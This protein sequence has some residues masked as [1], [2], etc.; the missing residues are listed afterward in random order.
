M[1]NFEGPYL[2][3][4]YYPED[5][6]LE[7]IDEDIALMKQAGMNLMRVGEFAWSRMEG[8]EG[9][10]DFDW[11]HM[12]VDKLGQSGIAVIMGTPTCTPP[13]WLVE[14]Y[15]EVLVV[16][17]NGQISQHG[18][19][20]HACPNNLVYRDYCAKIATKL[21]EEFGE[22]ENII[23]WQIDNE[24][25]PE[26]R[27]GRGCCCPVCHKKFQDSMHKKF[28]S[29]ESLNKA[30]GTDLWS[31]T[32][33]SF[34]QLPLPRI[35]TWHHPSLLTAWM[36]FQSDSYIEFTEHQ[37]EILHKLCRQPVGTDMMCMGG[38]N[39][40]KMHRN[41]DIVQVNNYHQEHDL[42][43]VV[44]WYDMIRSLKDK[45]FWNTETSTC[46]NGSTA[47]GKYRSEGFCRANSWLPIALGGE[48]VLYWLWRAHWSGQE[49]MHGSVISSS[50][51]PLH[52]INEVK[53]IAAGLH[54]SAEFINGT[55]PV[56]SGLAVHFSG[57]AWLMFEFQPFVN[58]FKYS[59]KLT[60]FYRSMIEASLRADVID[61]AASLD[62]YRVICSPFLPALDEASLRQRIKAWVKA[63]GIW[64]T[65]PLSDNLTMDAAKFKHSPFG[66]LEQLTETY[67][68]YQIPGD[69]K[70]FALRWAD[71]SES[72]GSIWYDGFEAGEA[73]VLATYTEQPLKGLAAVL[74]KKVGKG[75]IILLGTMPKQEDLKKLMLSV[76]GQAGIEPAA[77]A[78]SN[79]LVVPRKGKAG[80]GLI[81]VEFENR[82]AALTLA[83]GAVDLLTGKKHNG[84]VKIQPY[85]V[86]VLKYEK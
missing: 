13:I 43:R 30:W 48:A 33:Q 73:E 77:E 12:A 71:G 32:Y 81:A 23:G 9:K 25:Y 60:D 70:D 21:A 57:L 54:S 78:S 22:D 10:Y 36:E 58:N 31:Q 41:L 84:K 19:R 74:R 28:G 76:C 67:C 2:G 7:Q 45:P 46:W 61:P 55:R 53:E 34:S 68:N 75:Q 26:P 85:G 40:Y 42:W 29:I 65:G 14:K 15:P 6:P 72:C 11:L 64:I 44:F 79:L 27:G 62:S 3:A 82:S 50:G 63:G 4:A 24:L 18:G 49:M 17:E 47:A 39:Y 1:K 20:R 80:E 86:M 52:I 38:L 35:D 56:S 83:R 5:W 37:A 8:R 16:K 69:P 66:S 51:R 59:E